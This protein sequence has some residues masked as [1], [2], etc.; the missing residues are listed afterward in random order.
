MVGRICHLLGDMT[1]PAHTHC[2]SHPPG[3][4]DSYEEWM[5]NGAVYNT[6][7]VNNAIAKGG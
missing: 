7:T 4:L 3:D 2:D 6:W 1:V 5:D